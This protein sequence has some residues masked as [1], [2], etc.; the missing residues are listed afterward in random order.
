MTCQL[1]TAS[2][3]ARRR[4]HQEALNFNPLA[5]SVLTSLLLVAAFIDWRE[6]RIP[7]LLVGLLLIIGGYLYLQAWN[8]DLFIWGCLGLLTGLVLFL[9]FY[10][11]RGMGAGDVKLMAVCGF[12]LGPVAAAAAVGASLF[13]GMVMSLCY[14]LAGKLYRRSKLYRQLGREALFITV[15][16]QD[17]WKARLPFAGAIAAGTITV[18]VV[19]AA[20]GLKSLLT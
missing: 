2:G 5:A 16:D 17:L 10:A 7:N 3:C 8:F 13:A 4:P 18:L 20:V 11:M 15:P 9:P 6:H 14:V 12:Y 1:G 19:D